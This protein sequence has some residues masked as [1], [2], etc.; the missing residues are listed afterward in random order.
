VNRFDR[1]T[2]NKRLYDHARGE[3]VFMWV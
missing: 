3:N 1:K 2:V